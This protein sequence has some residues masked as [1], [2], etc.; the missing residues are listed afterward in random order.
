ME[1]PDTKVDKFNQS[2]TMRQVGWI[3]HKDGD[4]YPIF[5]GTDMIRASEPGGYSPVYME[6]GD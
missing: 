6:V 4:F 2:H 3:G 5:T 1:G